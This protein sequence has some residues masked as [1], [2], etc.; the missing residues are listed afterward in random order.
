M[1]M[2]VGVS[3]I[4]VGVYAATGCSIGEQ[5]REYYL[6]KTFQYLFLYVLIEILNMLLGDNIIFPFLTMF[7]AA[8]MLFKTIS[9]YK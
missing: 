8:F 7:M 9:F 5:S 2:S 3:L 6:G 1:F 4:V